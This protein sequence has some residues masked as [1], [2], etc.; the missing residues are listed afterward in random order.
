MEYK[1]FLKIHS[2]KFQKSI[3]YSLQKFILDIFVSFN[4][5]NPLINNL[6]FWSIDF[7]NTLGMDL[8]I[9]RESTRKIIWKYIKYII[10]DLRRCSSPFRSWKMVLILINKVIKDSQSENV[11]V[12]IL[13]LLSHSDNEFSSG[14]TDSLG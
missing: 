6:N 10:L 9:S 12:L 13:S 7:G 1:K 2:W 5:K 14:S 4:I 3:S 11:S 8:K